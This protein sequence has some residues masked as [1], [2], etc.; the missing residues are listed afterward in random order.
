MCLVYIT[1]VHEAVLSPPRSKQS[2][3]VYIQTLIVIIETACSMP[4]ML[5]WG[6]RQ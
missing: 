3:A 5:P 6:A 2:Y 4:G 1:A